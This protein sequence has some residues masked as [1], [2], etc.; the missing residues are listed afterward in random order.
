MRGIQSVKAIRPEIVAETGLQEDD[1]VLG[2]L[3]D[4]PS[5]P[6]GGREARNADLHQA[7]LIVIG[8]EV[9]LGDQALDGQQDGGKV[10]DDQGV[11]QGE[12]ISRLKKSKQYF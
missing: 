11:L 12:Q 2:V 4:G 9:W 1:Q 3:L 5:L 8:Q 10:L 7:L 6:D